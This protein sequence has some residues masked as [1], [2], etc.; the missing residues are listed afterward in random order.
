MYF[1]VDQHRR[2]RK[3]IVLT[4]GPGGGKTT[5]IKDLEDDPLF[6]GR[7]IP[8]PEAVFVALETGIRPT[9]KLFQRI[10]VNV[11]TA[12]EL[13]LD[14]SL[15]DD[16]KII[17]CHRGTLDPLAYWINN[18]WVEDEFYNYTNT[19]SKLHY[20]RYTAVIH[21]VTAADGA[22]QFYKRW[23]ESYRSESTE[24]AIALD[25][26]LIDVWKEH[27]NYYLIDNHDRGWQK[28]CRDAKEILLRFI[29]Q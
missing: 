17:I 11:Q 1:D 27:A 29:N 2:K 5:L 22:E 13:A 14:K 12:M 20:N 4:G 16:D 26:L 8:L 7:F 28:K 21:L 10:M 15:A 18:G 3:I 25:K 19:D 6:K 24:K 23:P 9:E